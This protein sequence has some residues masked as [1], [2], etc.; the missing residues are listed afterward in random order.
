MVSGVKTTPD[1]K[2]ETGN[3][4][5]KSANFK[6]KAAQPLQAQNESDQAEGQRGAAAKQG[7]LAASHTVTSQKLTLP[8]TR[9][10]ALPFS[11]NMAPRPQV[12]ATG[13]TGAAPGAPLTEAR[14][15]QIDEWV[16][17]RSDAS[18]G[19]LGFG[20]TSA[21]DHVYDALKD[22]T[23]F[24]L[25]P[26]EQRYL[27]DKALN[28]A[29]P[30]Q[31]Y[32]FARRF[33]NDAELRGIATESLAAK[34]AQL[35]Q[36]PQ[37]NG[38]ASDPHAQA[39]AY[40]LSALEASKDDDKM[41]AQVVNNLK[42]ED[43]ARFAQALGN[44]RMAISGSLSGARDRLLAA[45]NN[46]PHTQ[47]TSAVV[48]NLFAGTIPMDTLSTPSLPHD[49]AVA[50]AREWYPDTAPAQGNPLLQQ[51]AAKTSGD[52]GSPGSGAKRLAETNRLEGLLNT[53]QG[54]S[55][56]LAGSLEKRATALSAIRQ[57][58]SISSRALQ[59][60]SGD[61]AASP[62]MTRAMAEV[63]VPAQTD[64]RTAQVER[65]AGI[66]GTD[67]GRELL[68][69]SND[70]NQIP[71]QARVNARATILADSSIT[72]AKLKQTGDPWVNP[73]IAEPLAQANA[74]NFRQDGAQTLSGTN[75]DNTV[76]IAM[77]MP[78]TLPKGVT[79]QQAWA[80]ASA[81]DLSFYAQGPYHDSVQKVAD[82]I[83]NVGGA[84]AQVTVLPVTFSS[85]DSGP[86][87]L[88][89]F[90]VQTAAGDKYVDNTGRSYENFQDWKEHNQLPPGL[91]VYPEN[92]H[93]QTDER[94]SLKLSSGETPK[95][96]DTVGKILDYASLVGG[97]I[98]GGA[99]IIGTGGLG[100]ALVG[101]GAAAWGTYRT[102]GELKDRANHG[103]SIDPIHD[104][105]ARSLW[106]GLAA[107]ATGVG[108]FGSEAALARFVASESRLSQ[109]A[110]MT[111]GTMRV[112]ATVTNA[113]AF[114][115]A[116][117]GLAANWN[118]MNAEQW[119]TAL[120]QMG[121]WGLT[122]VMGA[123]QARTPGEIFNPAA[124]ARAVAEAYQPTVVRTPALEGNRVEVRPDA[125][126]RMTIFAGEKA[127]AEDIQAHLSVWR[128]RTHTGGKTPEP[129]PVKANPEAV[130]G[131]TSSTTDV[132]A[133]RAQDNAKL[134]NSPQF[135]KDMA[136]TG[137]TSEHIERMWAK[138]APLGFK[139]AE[140]FTQFKSELD[141][142]LKD[143]GLH[144]AEIR[145]RGTSTTF[146]SEN[147]GKPLGHH[148]D[149]NLKAPGDY[150]LNITSPSMVREFQK[151]G[152]AP[153]VEDGL[154]DTPEINNTFRDLKEFQ[155]KWTETLGR[156]V[157]FVG[158]SQSM[159]LDT[160][161][162]V[163]RK[164]K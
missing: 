119:T 147:P 5:A 123:R 39:R 2:P 12:N 126:G 118:S 23:E 56:L 149:A 107:N 116:G 160:T 91:M 13:Q 64:N 44:G 84:D 89:L 83:R 105:T 72:A 134:R 113:S 93:L 59:G 90:R 128:A 127:T 27:M 130:S 111:I 79:V 43:G 58:A 17:R 162:Y 133:K 35:M 145:L 129:E 55:L 78:A 88:P 18:G 29:G 40:A 120:L 136:K 104:S 50:L 65:L 1:F 33:Q 49:M 15:Q 6:E 11:A 98:A 87:Q 37:G 97:V 99:V 62:V 41:L 151:H 51:A 9:F 154:F 26:N 10:S 67:Q 80:K 156:D 74:A 137:V 103:E 61:P 66:L 125:N 95:S 132:I 47:T 158:Y 38:S 21:A 3:P 148:W 4:S 75:L 102:A 76:G 124:A 135:A 161:E 106:L 109:P 144:D 150:D 146:Y 152:I 114:T 155:K 77:G 70:S 141:T 86:V 22:K 81:G 52:S 54:Q 100:I 164:P 30:G 60:Q 73:V 139:D 14:K 163:V 71:P 20:Q 142:A 82:Q 34:A 69:G 157:N 153:G 138:E 121:F 19:I 48:Q 53:R 101:I 108:A 36:R 68:F 46:A 8:S 16:A 131:D 159:P 42:P 24:A 32:E 7:R 85:R 92:G 31:A 45:M 143:A 140:Q 94:G 57:D 25:K 63:M 112:A 117:V 28:R 96:G 110:A 122:S 115:D